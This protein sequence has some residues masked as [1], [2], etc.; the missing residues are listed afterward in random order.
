MQTMSLNAWPVT[1][2]QKKG[3]DTTWRQSLLR[4]DGAAGILVGL[5]VSGLTKDG[6]VHREL[7]KIILVTLSKSLVHKPLKT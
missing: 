4:Q 7:V 2:G 3:C 1:N 5:L 6:T